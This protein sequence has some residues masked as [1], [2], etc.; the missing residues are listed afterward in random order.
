MSTFKRLTVK[1]DNGLDEIYFLVEKDPG[2]AYT[3]EDLVK[4]G[5]EEKW[6][7][8]AERLAEYEDIKMSPEEIKLFLCD[9]GIS[10]AMRSRNLQK[11][12]D[13]AIE[14]LYHAAGLLRHCKSCAM[15][16]NKERCV[17]RYKKRKSGELQTCW[18]WRGLEDKG[19]E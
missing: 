16:N 4:G 2:G 1:V 5:Y 18:T 10:L 12:L 7:A 8:A 17:E 13:A 9:C 15:E 19:N 11:K 6:Q 14:D 3:L